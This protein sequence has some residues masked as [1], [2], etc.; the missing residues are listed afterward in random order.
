MKIIVDTREQLPYHFLTPTAAGTSELNQITDMEFKLMQDENNK[1]SWTWGS[2]KAQTKKEVLRLL[3]EGITQTEITGVL[4]VHK[5]T[6]SKIRTQAIKDGLLTSK[7]KLSQAG[8]L[9]INR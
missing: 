8:I 5:A 1:L 7:N 3:D 2:V 4:N 6:V 9:S